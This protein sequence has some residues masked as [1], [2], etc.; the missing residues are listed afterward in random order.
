M[1]G[2]P[3]RSAAAVKG[4]RS[5]QPARR[6][7][8]LT[9]WADAPLFAQAGCELGPRTTGIEAG[10]RFQLSCPF[11]A[12]SLPRRE[13]G[14]PD[15]AGARKDEKPGSS[16]SSVW[17]TRPVLRVTS[18]TGDQLPGRW[19]FSP[20]FPEHPPPGASGAFAS[21]DPVNGDADSV[22][23]PFFITAVRRRARPT[24]C[25]SF[26][27]EEEGRFRVSS[28]GTRHP[29][30]Q[31][32]HKRGPTGACVVQDPRF[33]PRSPCR[34]ASSSFSCSSQAVRAGRGGGPE[35]RLKPVS[36]SAHVGFL[37]RRR[38]RT[39]WSLELGP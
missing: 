18:V 26:V 14:R 20:A 1:G 27:L 29:H 32:P 9:V 12:H 8:R 38:D 39:P 31:L 28:S 10:F 35:T 2:K 21:S 22:S 17:L 25:R 11:R 30:T 6:R 23:A 33:C 16:G 5:R 37:G 34:P 19:R 7:P 36:A 13:E 24:S 3:P 15:G 4:P